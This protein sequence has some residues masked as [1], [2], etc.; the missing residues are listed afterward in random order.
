M[1]CSIMKLHRAGFSLLCKCN[2]VKWLWQHRSFQPRTENL[3][4]RIE[5]WDEHRVK[6]VIPYWSSFL[7]HWP[8]FDLECFVE[9][10]MDVVGTQS[11]GVCLCLLLIQKKKMMFTDRLCVLFDAIVFGLSMKQKSLLFCQ[12]IHW[13][14]EC[15]ISRLYWGC[16]LN[17]VL[18]IL[19]PWRICL[20][21]LRNKFSWVGLGA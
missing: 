2:P 1:N 16:S 17:L 14:F 5:S 11:S 10:P 13:I 7:T 12:S 8:P 4:K 6:A 9:V 19:L 18:W 21:K 3:M 20:G 15:W